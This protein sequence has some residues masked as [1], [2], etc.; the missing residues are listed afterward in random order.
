MEFYLKEKIGSLFGMVL[1]WSKVSA[2]KI[3]NSSI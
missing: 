1:V 2:L 3:L